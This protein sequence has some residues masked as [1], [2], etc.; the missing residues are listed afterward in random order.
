MKNNIPNISANAPLGI[1]PGEKPLGRKGLLFVYLFLILGIAFVYL[2]V[3]TFGFLHWDDWARLVENPHI[4]QGLTFENLWWALSSFDHSSWVP[5]TRISLLIDSKIYRM[6]PAGFHLTNLILHTLN[7]C[8]VF[9][10]FRKMT[11]RDYSS[12]LVAALFAFHP[13][14]V[15][16]VAWVTDRSGLLCAFFW[17]LCMRAYLKY[18]QHPNWKNYLVVFLYFL[19]ALTSKPMAITLPF[20]L[21]LLD[22]WPLHRDISLSNKN[23]T[24]LGKNLNQV[25]RSPVGD[26]SEERLLQRNTLAAWKW[27]IIEKLPLIIATAITVGLKIMAKQ[28]F[29]QKSISL[30]TADKLSLKL[31]N[32]ALAYVDYLKQTFAPTELSFL[33]IHPRYFGGIS[34]WQTAVA[35]AVLLL[36]CAFILW[37]TKQSRF[38][39]VGWLWFIGVLFP[40][41]GLVNN[42]WQSHAD[43]Y[44]Y[45]PHLGIFVLLVWGFRE[46]TQRWQ[47]SSILGCSAA[48]CVLPTLIFLSHQQTATWRNSRTLFEHGKNIREDNFIAI[49]S[50]ANIERQEGNL[51]LAEQLYLKS[52][53]ISPKTA[54]AQF[55]LGILYAQQGRDDEAI[56]KYNLAIKYKANYWKAYLSLGNLHARQNKF[57]KAKKYFEKALSIKPNDPMLIHKVTLT[58]KEINKEFPDKKVTSTQKL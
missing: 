2:Q 36:I 4:A 34:V 32:A 49:L 40:T 3:V 42:G 46:L 55:N 38:W 48:I 18:V 31:S 9:T 13:Q 21:L 33:Y 56:E 39:L 14:H 19:A 51:K 35:V 23:A 47:Y 25:E 12:A 7:S 50:L 30:F 57:V 27:L 17:L 29:N 54:I 24:K 52:L 26:L 6:N 1:V 41:I 20:A 44:T 53:D 11:N 45:L 43:R 22:F 58:R 16:S 10:V 28:S 5:A 37:K 15:E 8:L